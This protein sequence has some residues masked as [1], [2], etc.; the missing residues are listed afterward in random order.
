MPKQSHLPR[1]RDLRT[2]QLLMMAL[3]FAGAI[4]I[5]ATA[6]AASESTEQDKA[7]QYEAAIADEMAYRQSVDAVG[8]AWAED[9]MFMY[10]W[11][12]KYLSGWA[13]GPQ[14]QVEDGD[15]PKRFHSELAWL[16]VTS[17]GLLAT[18]DF[19]HSETTLA[20]STSR[21]VTTLMLSKNFWLEVRKQCR[22]IRD[23]RQRRLAEKGRTE[24]PAPLADCAEKVR[25]DLVMS[26]LV[27]SNV[28]LFVT[29]GLIAG[30]G[31]KL[32]TRFAAKWFAARVVPFIPI[33]IRSKYVV[34][35]IAVAMVTL[36]PVVLYAG[37]VHEHGAN[38]KFYDNLESSIQENTEKT[39]HESVLKSAALKTERE[40]FELTIWLNA[41]MPPNVSGS[42]VDE[43]VARDFV[44]RLNMYAPNVARL[45][46]KR[47]ELEKSRAGLEAELAAIPGVSSR[48]AQLAEERKAG[49]LKPDDAV[50]FHK[51]QYLASL[52]LVLRAL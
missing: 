45:K 48:L 42:T 6:G 5:S 3:A 18:Y 29:G 31:K 44:F 25:S 16:V 21:F 15:F 9:L 12:A 1:T 33:A 20:G 47:E 26:Q 37:I 46:E 13:S 17:Q 32:F 2:V 36:P 34:G 22:D 11:N 50:L 40:V 52:R 41:N 49:R 43:E 4:F 10:R 39:A 8:T 35:G 38:Q 30:A 14:F 28:S 51:A 23:L 27:G 24:T 7:A 19:K